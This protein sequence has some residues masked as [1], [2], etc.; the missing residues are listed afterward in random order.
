MEDNENNFRVEL[1]ECVKLLSL[2]NDDYTRELIAQ[3]QLDYLYVPQ[4]EKESILLLVSENEQSIKHQLLGKWC[5]ND[6]DATIFFT[7]VLDDLKIQDL[8]LCC[9]V[10]EDAATRESRFMEEPLLPNS[11][12]KNN[13]LNLY[14]IP[15]L[16]Q[17]SNK[18]PIT[19]VSSEP[20]MESEMQRFTLDDLCL[21]H[22]EVIDDI[23]SIMSFLKEN[24]VRNDNDFIVS[25]K[26][27]KFE[28]HYIEE[29]LISL[30]VNKNV[31]DLPTKIF[32]VVPLII[33][34]IDINIRNDQLVPEETD[35]KAPLEML[36]EWERIDEST[37]DIEEIPDYGCVEFEIPIDSFLSSRETLQLEPAMI[38]IKYDPLEIDRKKRRKTDFGSETD[39][40]NDKYVTIT[41]S[42]AQTIKS[43]VS[44][45][46]TFIHQ[47]LD[48]Q[49][50]LQS[51]LEKM[52]KVKNP[53]E[54]W[55]SV[56]MW[57]SM[58]ELE[59]L[60]FKVPQLSHPV[61]QITR[62]NANDDDGASFPLIPTKLSDLIA[63][64]N[65]L[66]SDFQ[67][68]TSLSGMKTLE[69]ELHWNPIKNT[70]HIEFEQIVNVKLSSQ[71][72]SD[73]LKD[74]CKCANDG[75]VLDTVDLQFF[76][77]HDSRL[78]A[79]KKEKHESS[80]KSKILELE[81]DAVASIAQK[82][83]NNNN[84]MA[85]FCKE[86]L[87]KKN[88][89]QSYLKSHHKTKEVPAGNSADIRDLLQEDTILSKMKISV[90]IPGLSGADRVIKW[91][92]RYDES[93]SVDKDNDVH[94]NNVNLSDFSPTNGQ[95]PVE[96]S[97]EQ[98]NFITLRNTSSMCNDVSSK[99][100]FDFKNVQDSFTKPNVFKSGTF[101][102]TKSINDFLFL[103]GK[104][105]PNECRDI[106]LK[107]RY[108]FAIKNEEYK[109]IVP[110]IKTPNHNTS[111][112][113]YTRYSHLVP[114]GSQLTDSDK[115][116][117]NE[118]NAHIISAR[119]LAN[120]GL[121]SAF[122]SIYC[123][124]EI[125]ERDFEYMRP[126]L[127]DDELETPY[128]DCDLIIDE[129]TGIIYYPLNLISQEQSVPTFARTII[130]L[131]QKYSS[132]YVILETYTWSNRTINN[133]DT[134]LYIL[135]YSFTLP[136]LKA[137]AGLQAI[138]T[139]YSCGAHI[140]FSSCEEISARLARLIGDLCASKCE[141]DRQQ[142][143]NREW[144]AMEESLHE[145]FL[146]CF[147]PLINPFTAQIIL[148]AISLPEFLRMT[149]SERYAMFGRWIDEWRLEKFETIIHTALSSNPEQLFTD[150][151]PEV[152]M[153]NDQIDVE[154]INEFKDFELEEFYK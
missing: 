126:L 18:L 45:D 68:L 138:L 51:D 20:F 63:R 114:S 84:F 72:I 35:V 64:P 1:L 88:S 133:D 116:N 79:R 92:S 54:N 119:L 94:T 134:G 42:L 58:D 49:T 13:D 154:W 103:R 27:F 5:L 100:L 38:P 33:N 24:D 128:I 104:I 70:S 109:Q 56:I 26:E 93:I 86:T 11:I 122:K 121:L 132:L 48:D 4:N 81:E 137:V 32:E 23:T 62:G 43:V 69:F 16:N 146:S 130:R 77:I 102:A 73:T 150:D 118:Q 145:R 21:S 149:Y 85:D 34:D 148:T 142:W 36:N 89:H 41:D 90:D 19:D 55:K 110:S 7:E 101:S 82:C 46:D 141:E 40:A 96:N 98:Q 143:E 97:N 6:L 123:K 37:F 152:H 3:I 39:D 108:N 31:Q 14:P 113:S 91:L 115:S 53:D 17:L 107:K 80:Q 99:A 10:Y 131:A 8:N 60:K 125:F 127:P 105:A 135:P 144:M 74:L 111:N 106:D 71:E 129:R 25:V 2:P 151:D 76:E 87:A 44:D 50:A 47:K 12:Q 139:R 59:G 15:T 52:L 153:D 140:I 124:V 83:I 9:D 95:V 66:H 65:S 57:Q 29:P 22:E 67:I 75:D 136:V 78:I 120:R 61:S 117:Q 147:S 112:D 30:K 28:D